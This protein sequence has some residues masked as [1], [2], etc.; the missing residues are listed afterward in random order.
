VHSVRLL[1]NLMPVVLV[2]PRQIY[3]PRW[4]VT[5]LS[6]SGWQPGYRQGRAAGQPGRPV[7]RVSLPRDYELCECVPKRAEPDPG[8][9]QNPHHVVAG[10]H[11]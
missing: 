6:L 3:W 10:R 9:W 1:L 4:T 7:Q 11:L 5:S 2:E 8:N